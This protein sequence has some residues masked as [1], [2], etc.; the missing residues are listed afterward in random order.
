MDQKPCL[1]NFPTFRTLKQATLDQG[2]KALEP[3]KKVKRSKAF[4]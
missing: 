2:P 1:R 4:F 3:K